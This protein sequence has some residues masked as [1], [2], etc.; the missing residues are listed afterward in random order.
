MSYSWDAYIWNTHPS[1]INSWIKSR[2]PLTLFEQMLT[3]YQWS[4]LAFSWGQCHITTLDVTRWLQSIWRLHLKIPLHLPGVNELTSSHNTV[5]TIRPIKIYSSFCLFP[6]TYND[7][8]FFRSDN[9]SLIQSCPHEIT[10]SYNY[11]NLNCVFAINPHQSIAWSDVGL[12]S[13]KTMAIQYYISD[14]FHKCGCSWR[15]VAN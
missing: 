1:T 8:W 2:Y 15:L 11:V 13:I 9:L 3:Y 4:P 14:Q 10:A 6:E 12:W 7:V 5:S